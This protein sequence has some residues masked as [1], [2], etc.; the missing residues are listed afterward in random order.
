[1]SSIRPRMH[2]DLIADDPGAWS[3]VSFARES[4]GA[5]LIGRAG[6][7]RQTP[8]ALL[9]TLA[10]TEI[11]RP[12]PGL[13]PSLGVAGAGPIRLIG[14]NREG[15]RRLWFEDGGRALRGVAPRVVRRWSVPDLAPGPHDYPDQDPAEALPQPAAPAALAQPVEGEVVAPGGRLV[16]AATKSGRLFGVA[17]L[18]LP[19]R[20]VV[21]FVAGA[22]AAA[23][24]EDG[25]LLAFG[26][27]WGVMLAEPAPAAV[28]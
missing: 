2:P 13:D 10:P 15:A 7:R 17:F 27:D 19:E 25:R 12:L 16:A 26:G 18:R 24:T 20:A 28:S 6:R 22:A 8:G 11:G 3:I 1:M 5:Q 23:W 9:S 21:R 14:L 4:Q